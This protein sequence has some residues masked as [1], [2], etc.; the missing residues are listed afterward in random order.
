[1]DY[2]YMPCDRILTFKEI[3]IDRYLE[4]EKL[5]E[6]YLILQ[7]EHMTI[8]DIQQ[9][10]KF[11][12]ENI[13]TLKSI[14]GNRLLARMIS[15]V[16][17]NNYELQICGDEISEIYST[18]K[19]SFFLERI[20]GHATMPMYSSPIRYSLAEFLKGKGNWRHIK[21]C[22]L[23]NKFHIAAKLYGS[24]KRCSICSKKTRYSPEKQREYMKEVYRPAQKKKKLREKQ[25]EQIKRLIDAGY[26]RKEANKLAM[27]DE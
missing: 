11:I 2:R 1:M 26:S 18:Y 15:S 13:I 22:E 27:I 17:T 5:P 6:Y 24:Q 21:K 3:P 23:C 7:N 10:L 4:I 16:N 19:E 8:E 14:S 9:D 12:I 25:N 20:L